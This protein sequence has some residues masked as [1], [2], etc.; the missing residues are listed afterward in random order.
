MIL[1]AFS[2]AI[3]WHI[4]RSSS[5][6][7]QLYRRGRGTSKQGD[8]L[9]LRHNKIYYPLVSIS[10]LPPIFF[11]SLVAF[12][13]RPL[14][15]P[16]DLLKEN[17]HH[18]GLGKCNQLFFLFLLVFHHPPLLRLSLPA[19]YV[20]S[21]SLIFSL[22]HKLQ[23]PLL[24]KDNNP[25]AAWRGLLMWNQ[26]ARH[27]PAHQKQAVLACSSAS[28]ETLRMLGCKAFRWFESKWNIKLNSKF[29]LLRIRNDLP[30]PGRGIQVFEQTRLFCLAPLHDEVCP[31]SAPLWRHV[32]EPSLWQIIHW[33]LQTCFHSKRVGNWILTCTHLIWE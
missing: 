11:V 32:T 18:R 30:S 2:L 8:N 10:Y 26:N 15:F 17:R 13:G 22:F 16:E 4:W 7:W 19:Q 27:V 21:I 25:E 33:S 3:S 23:P 1:V 31:S 29:I 12:N 9:S 20:V 5:L 28:P 14:C 6:N 24:R